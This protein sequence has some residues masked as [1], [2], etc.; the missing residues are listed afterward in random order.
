MVENY[1][2]KNEEIKKMNFLERFIGIIIKPRKTI[3]DIKERNGY[4]GGLIILISAIIVNIFWKTYLGSNKITLSNSLMI[5]IP[6]F[7]LSSLDVQTLIMNTFMMFL[8]SFAIFIGLFWLLAQI[9]KESDASV[10]KFLNSI[11]HSFTILLIG[12]LILICVVFAFP[13]LNFN[14]E[15]AIGINVTINNVTMQGIFIEPITIKGDSK[16]IKLLNSTIM[17]SKEINAELLNASRGLVA[18][19]NASIKDVNIGDYYIEEINASKIFLN[20]LNMSRF[21]MQYQYFDF[22]LSNGEELSS[23][24]YFQVLNIVY[25]YLPKILWIWITILGA[26]GLNRI[27]LVSRNKSIIAALLVIF[28]MLLTGLAD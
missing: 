8:I 10:L 1:Y 28:I 13:T 23:I 15:K 22:P 26:L 4:I 6:N 2:E 27:Y 18:L 7:I 24:P 19:Y 5:P 21:D 20:N 14:F 25:F 3:D 12:G 11:L 17:Y 16:A 9:M